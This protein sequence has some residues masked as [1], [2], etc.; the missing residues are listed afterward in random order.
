LLPLKLVWPEKFAVVQSLI[1]VQ[2]VLETLE[3]PGNPA[4]YLN[5]LTAAW[6]LADQKIPDTVLAVLPSSDQMASVSVPCR[7]TRELP[8]DFLIA[9]CGRRETPTDVQLETMNQIQSDDSNVEQAL[10]DLL[11]RDLE[12]LAEDHFQGRFACRL[13]EA[14]YLPLPNDVPRIRDAAVVE[15]ILVSPIKGRWAVVFAAPWYADD[16]H[17]DWHIACVEHDRFVAVWPGEWIDYYL[18]L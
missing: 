14:P 17:G 16:E 4:E 9:H 12:S 15:C 10:L 7:L 13:G 11:S 6:Q 8:A 1:P 3:V 2:S 5:D 18:W